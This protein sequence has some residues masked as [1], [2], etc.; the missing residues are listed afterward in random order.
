MG[1]SLTFGA[2]AHD[3]STVWINGV[4]LFVVLFYIY[5]LKFLS[6]LPL[7]VPVR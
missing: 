1:T 6:C 3:A 4:L 7:V 5:P 2:L